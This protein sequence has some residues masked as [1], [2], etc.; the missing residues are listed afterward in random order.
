MTVTCWL[1]VPKAVVVSEEMA[2]C[3]AR[4]S[5]MTRL[6]RISIMQCGSSAK[7]PSTVVTEAREM[8]ARQRDLTRRH[9]CHHQL[10]T[11]PSQL[12]GGYELLRHGPVPHG[13]NRQGEYAA[14]QDNRS[15]WLACRQWLDS[16]V[17]ASREQL[18]YCCPCRSHPAVPSH[19]KVMHIRRAKR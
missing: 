2:C 5:G 1:C 6:K 4:I 18:F 8:F 15:L 13:A 12:R 3:L 10:T 19:C 9:I 7:T 11:C 14:Q 17:A 16:R